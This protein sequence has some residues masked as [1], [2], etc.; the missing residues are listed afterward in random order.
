LFYV[1]YN[2]IL[3]DKQIPLDCGINLNIEYSNETDVYNNKLR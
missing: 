2:I 1:V 3:I